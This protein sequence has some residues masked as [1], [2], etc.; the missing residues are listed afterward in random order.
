MGVSWLLCLLPALLAT[1][2]VQGLTCIQCPANTDGCSSEKGT[3]CSPDKNA[4]GCYTV[5]E[6]STLEGISSAKESSKGCIAAINDALQG[7]LTFTFGPGWY[8]RINNKQCKE[9]DCNKDN[10]Q[11]PQP[12]NTLN[13]WQCPSCFAPKATTCS[14]VTV[15]CAGNENLCVKFTGQIAKAGEGAA[16]TPFAAQGCATPSAKNIKDKNTLVSAKYTFTF[17]TA[18]SEAAQKVPSKNSGTSLAPGKVPFA[19]FLPGVT[20][21]L[22]VKLLS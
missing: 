8:V 22:L 4:V 18:T 12:N 5:T 17:T 16:V 9:N 2:S 19:L 15:P 1:A 20:G 14:P 21:L 11:V 13:G 3:E 10:L 6:E 7:V